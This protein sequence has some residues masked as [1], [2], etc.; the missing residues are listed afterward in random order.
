MDMIPENIYNR[1]FF[2]RSASVDHFAARA[3]R[4]RCRL[5]DN[6]EHEHGCPAL[7]LFELDNV[8]LLV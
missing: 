3:Y 1:F 2:L 4:A 8:F 5:D 6:V 7:D